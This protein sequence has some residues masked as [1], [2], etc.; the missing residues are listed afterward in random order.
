MTVQ[1]SVPISSHFMPKNDSTQPDSWHVLII[2]LPLTEDVFDLVFQVP[3][4]CD[5]VD[6]SAQLLVHVWLNSNTTDEQVLEQ[7]IKNVS[8]ALS[9]AKK[10]PN[11]HLR[12]EY[13]ESLRSSVLPFAIEHPPI[14]S[15]KITD[16][17]K[18]ENTGPDTV[19][20]EDVPDDSNAN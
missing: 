6:C 11:G 16:A 17:D 20:L 2:D 9:L 5:D 3:I 12:E 14:K 10:I 1:G 7:R 4:E 15:I 8:D 18:S 13:L 19:S